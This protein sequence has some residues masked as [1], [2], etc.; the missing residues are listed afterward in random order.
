MKASK[1]KELPEK[2]VKYHPVKSLT[3]ATIGIFT[4]FTRE[5][6]LILQLLIGVF[7]FII[8]WTFNIKIYGLLNIFFM[9]LVISVEMVNS[10][11]ETLCDLLHPAYS[12]KIKIVKDIMAGSVLVVS[13]TWLALLLLLI[14][15]IPQIKD[16]I[17]YSLF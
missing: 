9:A 11:M 16:Y 4:A 1:A 7:F 17:N 15:N 10:A 14:L 5:P 6:N 12:P 3:Y 13:L 2:V 8:A